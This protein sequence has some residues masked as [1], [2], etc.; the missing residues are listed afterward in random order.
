MKPS[1]DPKSVKQDA[2]EPEKEA[3]Q[4]ASRSFSVSKILKWVAGI[5][6]ALTL[7]HTAVR[8]KDT[9]QEKKEV[10]DAAQ[11]LVTLADSQLTKKDYRAA[12][13]SYNQVL[14][15]DPTNKQAL[16]Q[17]TQLAMTWC[18]N[19]GASHADS[20][21]TEVAEK[22]IPAIY[23]GSSD[24]SGE[25]RGEMTAHVAWCT[26]SLLGDEKATMD[27]VS[28]LFAQA[29]AD[30][31]EGPYANTLEGVFQL[32]RQSKLSNIPDR[33]RTA[34]Q[35]AAPA[36]QEELLRLQVGALWNG[37]GPGRRKTALEILHEA[38][39]NKVPLP[40]AVGDRVLYRYAKE[41]SDWSASKTAELIPPK[42]SLKVL[43]YLRSSLDKEFSLAD[44][45]TLRYQEAKLNEAVG[46]HEEALAMLQALH[47]EITATP[48]EGHGKQRFENDVKSALE[49]LRA[50][51][52]AAV[53]R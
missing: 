20:V 53:A 4:G 24:A 19:P 42:Q 2:S 45:Q 15:L 32:R 27:Q 12:W 28:K 47:R 49:K 7:A 36:D 38:A 25:S 9:Y 3:E 26:I 8:L 43:T 22:L 5:S 50:K 10:D 34:R 52:G 17:Q 1:E 35:A 13:E 37:G 16:R 23:R 39:E 30:A 14:E 40:K 21:P 41:W 18:R 33:F 44:Q 11:R 29:L 46:N 6:T 48:F 51:P 31:P